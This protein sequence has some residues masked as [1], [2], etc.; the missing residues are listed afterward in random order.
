MFASAL[1]HSLK[2]LL[3]KFQEKEDTLRTVNL[4]SFWDL[5]LMK[6]FVLGCSELVVHADIKGN[7]YITIITDTEDIAFEILAK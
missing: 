6:S 5:S 1:V 4:H 2:T 3:L 7:V